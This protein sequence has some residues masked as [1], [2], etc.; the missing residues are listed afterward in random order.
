MICFDQ[1]DRDGGSGSKNVYNLSIFG[2]GQ[3]KLGLYL[4]QDRDYFELSYL[5][6]FVELMKNFEL[7]L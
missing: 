2:G 7:K 4:G 1:F 3:R 6:I 5:F